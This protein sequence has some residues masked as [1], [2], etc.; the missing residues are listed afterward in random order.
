MIIPGRGNCNAFEGK[1]IR[2]RETGKLNCYEDIFS[3]RFCLEWVI[4]RVEI[5]RDVYLTLAVPSD[6]GQ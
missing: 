3:L 6:A 4:R 1:Q 5:L 2:S